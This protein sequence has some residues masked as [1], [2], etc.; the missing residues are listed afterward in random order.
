MRFWAIMSR[1][2]DLPYPE[3][4]F[5]KLD[6]DLR[7]KM[8]LIRALFKRHLLQ[9]FAGIG[10]KAGVVFRKLH[11]KRPIFEGREELVP[12]KL[13]QRHTALQRMT[14]HAGAEDQVGHPLQGDRK[15][16]RLNSSHVRIS[17]AVFCLKK[18]KTKH[19]P[20]VQNTLILHIS[21]R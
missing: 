6:Q 2:L 13:V 18:K 11:A 21:C 4:L 17:Y 16:T 1:N 10:P 7:V 9:G 14:G 5:L 20:I 19:S 8:K 12:E 3:S 15:S